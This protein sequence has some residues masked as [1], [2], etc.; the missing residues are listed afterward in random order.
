MM[1]PFKQFDMQIDEPNTSIHH[2]EEQERSPKTAKEDSTETTKVAVTTAATTS[3]EMLDAVDSGE[4][5]SEEMPE[6]GDGGDGGGHDHQ[7][8]QAPPPLSG[9]LLPLAGELSKF[10]EPVLTCMV[11][12]LM[13]KCNPPQEKF[14]MLG[15]NPIPAPW[16]PTGNEPWW[17]EVG[18][19][20]AQPPYKRAHHLSAADKVV[21]M[22][23]MIKNIAPDFARLTL[24]MQMAKSVTNIITAA[25]ADIWDSAIVHERQRYMQAHAGGSEPTVTV[26]LVR[27]DKPASKKKKIPDGQPGQADPNPAEKKKKKMMKPSLL[28]TGKEGE[29]VQTWLPMS[30]NGSA[31]KSTA[32][33]S[34]SKAAVEG[35]GA[36]SSERKA[37]KVI[38]G[39]MNNF[40]EDGIKWPEGPRC[41]IPFPLCRGDEVLV[42]HDNSGSATIEGHSDMAQ[43]VDIMGICS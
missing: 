2:V 10:S 26:P 22:V 32:G 42:M 40:A 43:P 17:A 31:A 39:T 20:V 33:G 34:S 5:I 18:E 11:Q 12:V 21:V 6:D 25:E 23:A 24:A 41:P 4:R 37:D 29:S 38:H 36:P 19:G 3:Q 9:E 1:D 14:P 7:P 13:K 16:W 15:K 35:V 28:I 8:Q 30:K 27:A